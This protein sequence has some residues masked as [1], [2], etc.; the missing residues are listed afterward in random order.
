MLKTS[1]LKLCYANHG[2]I[3]NIIVIFLSDKYNYVCLCIFTFNPYLGF[4]SIH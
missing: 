3:Y 4:I 1:A 2:P